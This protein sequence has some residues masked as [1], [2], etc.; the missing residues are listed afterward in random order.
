MR[1]PETNAT[2][3]TPL[4][5]L[6][7]EAGVDRVVV[8]GFATDYCVAAT[9]HDAVRLNLET[10]VVTDATMAVNVQEG[11]GSRALDELRDA[12]VTLASTLMR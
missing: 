1:D 10:T 2:V 11:D 4:E 6:L 8:V 5:M 9:A 12:G 7:Q 3:P